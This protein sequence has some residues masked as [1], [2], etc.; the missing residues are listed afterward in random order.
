[1]TEP[2]EVRYTAGTGTLVL[3][4]ASVFGI[5]TSV[6]MIGPLLVDLAREFDIPLGRAGLLATV[7]AIPWALASPFAGL[8][9]DRVG[10]RP[11]IV[12]ALGGVGIMFLCAAWA[13]S[14]LALLLLRFA[15]GLVGACGP[16]SLMASVGDLFPPERRARAMGWFNM[17]FG[18]AAVVGVPL[19]GAVGGAWGW[20]WAFATTGTA[21]VLLALVIQVA[22]PPARATVSDWRVLATYRTVLEVPRLTNVLAANLFERS[23]FAMMAFY[24]PAFLMLRYGLSAVDVA[25]VLA[26]VAGGAIAGNVLGGWLGDRFLR[27]VIFLMSQLVAGGVSVVLFGLTLPFVLAVALGTLFGLVNATSRPAFLAL[28]SELAPVHRGALFGLFGLTNQG[29]LVLGSAVGGL[30]IEGV[31]YG[32]VGL[33]ALC[34]GCLAAGLALPLALRG[35]GRFSP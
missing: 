18:L 29:G 14:F 19:V 16:T 26:V 21:L 31:G 34:Q 32:G 8:I 28:G 11:M 9:S 7:M 3:V 4:T 35:E 30:V 2:A 1:M 23:M 6:S 20:R 10:R 5:F 25:P 27:P 12:V 33:V 22:F 24:L 17:G 15:A 13:R